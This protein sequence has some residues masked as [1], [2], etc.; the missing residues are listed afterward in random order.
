MLGIGNSLI[1][2]G[3][4][5]E[6]LPHLEIA[7]CK[8]AFYP[9]KGITVSGDKVTEW[10]D[11]ADAHDAAVVAT[12][13]SGAQPVYNTTHLTF[14]GVNDILEL[15]KGGSNFELDL[16]TSDGGWTIVMIVTCDEWD[17]SNQV[18]VGVVGNSSFFIR[19][20]SGNARI[21]V[22]V[23]GET[24]HMDTDSALTDG[25]YY[26]L[27]VTCNAAGSALTLYVDN[28]AQADTE[29]LNN[30]GND[31][32]IESFGHR[33]GTDFIDGGMKSILAW[34]RILTSDERDLIDSWA[35]QYKG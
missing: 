19:H 17:A 29:S 6:F 34:D 15:H 11:Q 26:C 10:A 27:I 32:K 16:D 8:L 30:N 28:T 23:D 31:M 2:G 13:G 14:D 5:S 3:A 1:T 20:A 33:G 4:V 25:Q 7:G 21:T 9:D 22:K 35:G 12:A 24:N 18:I